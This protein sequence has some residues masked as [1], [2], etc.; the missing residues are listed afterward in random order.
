MVLEAEKRLPQS[1][2]FV[3]F[4]GCKKWAKMGLDGQLGG[5][6]GGQFEQATTP[7]REKIKA[8]NAKN[9]QKHTL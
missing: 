3:A 6:L 1:A 8:K 5:Q 7:L 2:H 9:G 4:R